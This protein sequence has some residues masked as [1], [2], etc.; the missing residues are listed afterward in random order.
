MTNIS[1]VCD[2]VGRDFLFYRVR[3]F[4][5]IGLTGN[6]SGIICPL[7]IML[8]SNI[9]YKGL[10]YVSA[11]NTQSYWDNMPFMYCVTFQVT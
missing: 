5:G 2:I 11:Y 3:Y 9:I 10:Y 6:Q 7:Y 1:I 4:V 8:R